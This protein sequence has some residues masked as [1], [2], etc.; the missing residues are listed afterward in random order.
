MKPRRMRLIGACA[1]LV[2]AAVLAAGWFATQGFAAGSPD[3]GMPADYLAAIQVD[4]SKASTAIAVG[5]ADKATLAA[6]QWLHRTDAPST[7]FSARA[8]QYADSPVVDVIVVV[9]RTPGVQNVGP[10]GASGQLVATDISG[11]IIDAA[12]GE[13]L[14][15]FQLGRVVSP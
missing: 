10:P 1:G 5:Q 4:V 14:K 8:S 2:A 6:Q 7:V 9:F 3:F 12:T 13:V 11:A 15:S